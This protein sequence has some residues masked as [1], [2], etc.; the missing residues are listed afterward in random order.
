MISSPTPGIYLEKTLI[1]KD[2]CSPVF[3]AALLNN[4]QDMEAT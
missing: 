2:T 4:S 1:W 3:I